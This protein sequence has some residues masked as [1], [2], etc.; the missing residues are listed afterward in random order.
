MNMCR[1]PIDYGKVLIYF[2]II[3]DVGENGTRFFPEV[4]YFDDLGAYEGLN[5]SKNKLHHRK[6]REKLYRIG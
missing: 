5:K 6:E 2:F 1:E 3:I 4:G